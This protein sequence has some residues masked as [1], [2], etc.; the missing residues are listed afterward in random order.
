MGMAITAQ[1]SRSDP[2][3]QA[4]VVHQMCPL[5]RVDKRTEL[6]TACSRRR[7]VD[8]CHSCGVSPSTCIS[9]YSLLARRPITPST[10]SRT[11]SPARPPRREALEYGS[12][13]SD[14]VDYEDSDRFSANNARSSVRA[15]AKSKTPDSTRLTM[16]QVSV[17][18][19]VAKV[20]RRPSSP[21][22]WSPKRASVTPSL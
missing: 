20:V 11:A 14:G 17:P 21:N 6:H 7:S 16:F 12:Q 22:C 8:Y 9:S 4:D 10:T 13:G 2:E 18:R 19:A 5:W 1:R 15:P 3:R